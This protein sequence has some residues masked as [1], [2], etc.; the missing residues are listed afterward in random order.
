[1]LSG[2]AGDARV[3]DLAKGFVERLSSRRNGFLAEGCYQ[4]GIRDGAG[5]QH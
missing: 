5:N 2:R 1:V 3:I 4:F